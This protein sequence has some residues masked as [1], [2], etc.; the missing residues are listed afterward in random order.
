MSSGDIIS[1]KDDVHV[2]I[3]YPEDESTVTETNF[4]IE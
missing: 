3:S 4:S 2:Q 1:I